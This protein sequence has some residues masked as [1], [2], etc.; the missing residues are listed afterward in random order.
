MSGH[1]QPDGERLLVATRRPPYPLGGSIRAHRLLTG[2][3][4]QFE[5][6]LLSYAQR[7]GS[8]VGAVQREQLAAAL[9]GVEVVLAPGLL[10]GNRRRDRSGP[11]LRVRTSNAP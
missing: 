4:A 5:T 7:P 10:P 11:I 3:A 2:L 6:T 1:V 9:P 8:S